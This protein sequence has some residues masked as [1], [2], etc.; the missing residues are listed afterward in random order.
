MKTL[1]SLLVGILVL[2]TAATLP[3]TEKGDGYKVGDKATDFLL[4][5]TD[6]SVVSM[7]D[8]PDAKGFIITFTCNHCPYA[9][10]YED[11]LID[12]HNEYAPKGY[13][14]IA[15][16]PNDPDVQPDDSF[17]K[18]KERAK[19]KEFPFAYLFDMDQKVY[20]EY[21]ATKTPHIFLLDAEHVVRYI[22]AID[23]NPQDAAAVSQP[24]LRNAL[25]A[26]IAGKKVKPNSTKAIG[27]SIKTKA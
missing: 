5:S 18:M 10:M 1:L 15:I 26:M 4:K 3:L 24:Y 14:V 8:Y 27:C 12:I 20:P 16:N 6:G 13:P 19:E 22:G 2:S 23:D 9:V 25:N 7:G 21:G 17:V 11:R